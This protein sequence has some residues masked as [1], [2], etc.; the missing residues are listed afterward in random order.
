MTQISVGLQLDGK[1]FSQIIF[2]EDKRAFE[3]FTSGNFEF[4]AK[5]SAIAIAGASA[6]ASTSGNSQREWRLHSS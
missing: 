5:A 4:G 3:E 6:D 2:F 1:A